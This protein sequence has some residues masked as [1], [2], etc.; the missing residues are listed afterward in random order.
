MPVQLTALHWIYLG[1]VL[2]VIITMAARRDTLIPTIL[3]LFLIGLVAKGSLV[4]ALQVMFNALIAA[5]GEFWGLITVISLVVA[6]S[7]SLSDVGADHLI[8][9]P[10]AVAMVNSDVAFWVT[11]IGMLVISWF[12][13][14]SPAT[15]LIG[16]IILP[17]AIRAG[18]PA[19]GAAAAMNLFGHGAALSSDF[20]IQ[21][22]PGISAKTAEIGVGDVISG[23]P[24]WLAM[25]VVST[26]TAWILLRRDI[27][28][29]KAGL[30][31]DFDAYKSA[32]ASKGKERVIDRRQFTTVSY[33]AAVLT[34]VAFAIDIV[35]IIAT[36]N[37]PPERAIRGG[38]AT[39]LIGGTALGIAT[40]VTILAHGPVNALEKITDFIRDGFLFGI[41]VF[42]PVVVIG[43]F[44]FL[45]S[46]GTAKSILG[47]QAT[48]FLSDFGTALAQ[49]VPLSKIPV[50]FIQLIIGG[51]TGL[52][53]SGFS[54]LPLTG[55]LARTFG[56]AV[57][58]DIG[59]LAMVGQLSAVWVG[60][61]TIIP[62]GLIPVAAIAGVN[63]MDL[64]RRNFLPVMLGFVAALLVAFVIV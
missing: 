41:K 47:P 50:V 28:A 56:T 6:L 5:G 52:D 12:V 9:R 19:M 18:L 40:I 16:A 7:K 4:G 54:G 37:L 42:A 29:G 11:G 17:V 38:A 23:W 59:K 64:A 31:S 46:E 33:I 58:L 2:L 57:S 21:A 44:F 15:A 49:A 20:V 60:G 55:S 10:A 22:A 61:G 62:W 14:P 25:T 39:A 63:P 27:A 45:G 53:G 36:R 30:E 43:G 13:W 48:G 1:V 26:V 3:G 35:L 32:A 8:M 34:V 51:I 24:I